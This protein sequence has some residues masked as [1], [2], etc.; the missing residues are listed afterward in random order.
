MSRGF[1]FARKVLRLTE[2]RSGARVCDPQQAGKQ[3]AARN[4]LAATREK[5]E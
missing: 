1:L 3:N 5:Y 4:F 2:A